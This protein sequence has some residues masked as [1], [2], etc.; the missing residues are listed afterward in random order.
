MERRCGSFFPGI[1]SCCSDNSLVT[2][3]THTPNGN[4]SLGSFFVE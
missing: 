4:Q 1:P 3:S 2:E